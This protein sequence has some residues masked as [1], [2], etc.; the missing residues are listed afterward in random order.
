MKSTIGKICTA[1]AA[2]MLLGSCAST[3]LH[4]EGIDDFDH[5]RYEV[6][7]QKLRQAAADNPDNLTYKLD[8]TSRRDEAISK[9]IAEGDR[10]FQVRSDRLL[11][12]I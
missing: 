6:G 2:A 11:H 4:K 8:V 7:L 12:Q 3:K 10:A 5:G 1:I 9:L